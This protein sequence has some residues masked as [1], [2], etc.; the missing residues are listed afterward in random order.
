MHLHLHAF[1]KQH[2][3]SVRQWFSFNIFHLKI[4]L[5]TFTCICQ[6]WCI[7]TSLAY[8]NVHFNFSIAIQ[9]ST[10]LTVYTITCVV[11]IISK[12]S[13][14]RTDPLCTSV[15]AY[16]KR[17]Q[18]IFTKYHFKNASKSYFLKHSK[19]SESVHGGFLKTISI[20]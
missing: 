19:T 3:T 10:I 6:A 20:L 13:Y 8:T 5:H 12:L 18:Q 14:H 4:L 16:R 2:F 11:F 17:E 1:L 7:T 9:S 15:L